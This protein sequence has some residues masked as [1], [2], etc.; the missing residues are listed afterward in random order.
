MD[1]IHQF[2]RLVR[3]IRK[4]VTSISII[5]VDQYV[6]FEGEDIALHCKTRAPDWGTE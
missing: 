6:R 4:R 2:R 5:M 1:I 3:Q